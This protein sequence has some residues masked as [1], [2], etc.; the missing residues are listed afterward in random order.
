MRRALLVLCLA[1][2]IVRADDGHDAH[3]FA[4]AQFFQAGR[5]TEALVEFRVAERLA[6]DGGPTWYVASTLVKLRRPEEALVAFAR[7]EAKDPADRDGLF[8]Y[9]QAL[10]CY[11]ARL[12]HCADR[13]LTAVGDGAGPRIAG[14]ARKIR[15]DLAPLLSAIAPPATI[16][17][18]HSRG[19]T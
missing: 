14:Q 19:Q 10:A 7:A 16:D 5:F 18:Y 4:G 12:Y 3:L 8:D 11:D 13:L 9:Y 6:N 17:W 15:G 2:T 1:A